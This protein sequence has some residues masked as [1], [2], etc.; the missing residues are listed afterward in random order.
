[1]SFHGENDHPL[2]QQGFHLMAKPAG[3]DCNLR[4]SYCFYCEKEAFFPDTSSFRMSDQVLDAYTR[5]YIAAQLGPELVFDWQGGEPT[6]LGIKFFKQA[7]ELQRKYG[8]GRQIS[9]TLQ[10]NG[11][12]L[13]DDWCRFLAQNHFLVG[14]SMDGPE[15]VHDACRIDRAG[16]ATFKRVF[17]ALKL[18]Q[19]HGVELNILA[20][21]NRVSSQKPLEVYRF[22]RE[23]GVRFIQFIPI[24]G[25]EAGQTIAATGCSVEP[26][27]YGACMTRIFD[28]WLRHDV[29]SM[30]VMNFEWTLAAWAGAGPG[31]CW[32][33]P[34]C[35]GNLILEHNGDIYSCD[36]FMYPACRIGNILD[37]DLNIVVQ[38]PD[39][40]AFGAAKETALPTCC[41]S[42]EHLFV[43]QGGC[44]KHR[45]FIAP[46]GEPGLNYLCEGYQAF[47]QHV[48]PAMQQMVQLIRR[49]APVSGIMQSAF[50]YGCQTDTLADAGT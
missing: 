4:C 48:R 38:S 26:K 7:L 45:F 6:L 43:C 3:P 29:G 12:L 36:H 8:E 22:F 2:Q 23:Q 16:M 34:R 28:E 11:I 37:G 24:V 47:H 32:L 5:E 30:F 35:G 15:E 9:N 46:D 27:Q 33:A 21:V 49:G 40:I 39:Q 31:V 20:T 14:L 1:M 10:T 50:S 13:D 41:R 42:C 18:L 19:K 17:S 25:Q 44:P